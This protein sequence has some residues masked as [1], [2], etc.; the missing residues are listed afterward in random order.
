MTLAM[1]V[2]SLAL[3]CWLPANFPVGM[4]GQEQGTALMVV[5]VG[6]PHRRA[7]NNQALF[8][9][10]AVAL[11]CIP[12]LLQEVRDH[13]DVVLVDQCEVLD[14]FLLS[15]VMRSRVKGRVYSAAGIDSSGTVPSHFKRENPGRIRCES[16]CLQIEHELDVVGERVGDSNGCFGKGASFSTCVVVF[17][18]L[19]A[20]VR[21][22]SLRPGI[23]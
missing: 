23:G 3:T 9:Q 16:Q 22:L 13:A 4:S 11:G 17:N 18:S 15:S 19:D 5:E 21:F 14:P 12:E 2:P 7:I 1:E 10:V 20:P 8:E 6:V